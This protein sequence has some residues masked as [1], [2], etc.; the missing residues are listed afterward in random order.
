MSLINYVTSK[1]DK[2]AHS[3]QY[4]FLTYKQYHQDSLREI[5]L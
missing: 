2:A 4:E 5:V 3:R 1:D